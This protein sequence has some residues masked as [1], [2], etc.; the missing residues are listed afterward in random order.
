MCTQACINM[1]Y[2][3]THT[4]AHTHTHTH[5]HTHHSHQQNKETF[6]HHAVESNQPEIVKLLLGY[7]ANPAVVDNHLQTPLHYAGVN[8]V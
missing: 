7:E 8:S 6:L 4:H 3:H 2:T 1:F 5:T